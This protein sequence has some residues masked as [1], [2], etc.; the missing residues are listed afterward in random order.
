MYL[1]RNN[2][3]LNYS[4]TKA[5]S[6]TA[7]INKLGTLTLSP[8]LMFGTLVVAE[9]D[10]DVVVAVDEAGELVGVLATVGEGVAVVLTVVLVVL[11]GV[12]VELLLLDEDVELELVEVVEVEVDVEVTSVVDAALEK[13]VDALAVTDEAEPDTPVITKRAE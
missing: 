8:P 3:T 1:Y 11:A 10:G 12:D 5:P 2:Y 7:P 4:I 9:A 6:P 13:D